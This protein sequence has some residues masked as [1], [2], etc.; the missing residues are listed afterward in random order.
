MK[1]TNNT[2]MRKYAFLKSAKSGSNCSLQKT[3]KYSD[4]SRDADS[5]LF[6][7][8]YQCSCILQNYPKNG[9]PV[10]LPGFPDCLIRLF[11]NNFAFQQI[12]A[13]ERRIRGAGIAQHN[14]V[15]FALFNKAQ[16]CYRT[17]GNFI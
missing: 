17:G 5:L 3:W 4:H 1:A 15:E 12:G 16:T 13:R 6:L 9:R 8:G 2:L 7:T 14:I 11:Y 10:S